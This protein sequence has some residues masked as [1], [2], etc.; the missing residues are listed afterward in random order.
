MYDYNLPPELIALEPA[1]SR[2]RSK[3]FIY[4]TKADQIMFD[5]FNHLAKYLPQNS[6]LVMNNT[7]VLPARVE[8]KKQTG[9]KLIALFLINEK[10]EKGKIKAM[11]DRKVGLG[12]RLYIDKDHFFTVQDQAEHVFDLGYDFDEAWFVNKLYEIGK[13]P[14]PLYLRKTSLSESELRKKYQTIFARNQGSVAAP[15]A[16]LHFTEKVFN[17]L[18]TKNIDRQY[19]TLHVGLG[20]FAPV[21]KENMQRKKLHNELY[22]IDPQV[23]DI[24]Y[25]YKQEGKKLVA[26][27]TTVT[28]ALESYAKSKIKNEKSKL[29]VK[30]QKDEGDANFF[31]FRGPAFLRGDSRAI[32]NWDAESFNKTDLFILPPYDFQMVDCLITNF[33]LPGS[34]LMMLV[35]ALLQHK[36]AKRHLVDLYKIAIKEKFRFYSFGDAML[37]L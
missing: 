20:T 15:T 16:S 18:N 22:E 37:I 13:T 24:I 14:I 31:R 33:H 28:R 5:H 27:G 36:H 19:I 30:N 25:R 1:A 4:D 12:D 2:D 21:T 11:V 23:G 26:V 6:F 3:L 7:K 35:E 34:S 8:L 32:K 10:T 17:D 29:Q 9:G